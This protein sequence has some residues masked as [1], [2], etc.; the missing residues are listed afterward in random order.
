[1]SNLVALLEGIH[2]TYAPRFSALSDIN[3]CLCEGEFAYLTGPSGAGKTTLLKL[4]FALEKPTKGKI[5]VN[6]TN[7]NT[8][9]SGRLPAYR[10]TVG[11]VFQDFRLILDRTVYENVMLPLQIRGIKKQ[12]QAYRIRGV[13]NLVGLSEKESLYPT[14]LSAGEKQRLAIARSL[15]ARPQLLLADEPTGNLDSASARQ[16]LE[17]LTEVRNLGT[18]VLL[19]THDDALVSQYPGRVLKLEKGHLVSDIPVAQGAPGSHPRYRGT[20]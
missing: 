15:I 18:A 10:R 14:S 20:A 2:K 4:M 6:Q 13:L 11:F 3:F 1:M 12:D 8:L 16:I 9:G 17:L 5:E 19:A 7:L